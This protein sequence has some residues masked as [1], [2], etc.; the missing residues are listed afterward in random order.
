M[1]QAI[2]FKRYSAIGREFCL[3]LDGLKGKIFYQFNKKQYFNS[4]PTVSRH[5]EIV[6]FS[7]K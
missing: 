3:L 6:L 2:F 5:K 1:V 7:K 4:H